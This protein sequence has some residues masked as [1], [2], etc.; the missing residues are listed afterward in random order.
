MNNLFEQIL[1]IVSNHRIIQL[2]LA[3][4]VLDTFLGVLRAFKEHKFN[5]CVGIDGAIR[6]VAM[7]GSLVCLLAVDSIMKINVIAFVPKEITSIVGVQTIGVCEF[8]SL[9]FICYETVS[10]LKN[11]T[12]CGIWLPKK[13]KTGIEKWLINMTGELPK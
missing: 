4:I 5:S 2:V 7:L 6:K 3:V 9:L 1:G 10:I 11:W 8:F 13:L 12:L